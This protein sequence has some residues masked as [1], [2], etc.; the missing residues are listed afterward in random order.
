MSSRRGAG[1]GGR[2]LIAGTQDT[3]MSRLEELAY[4]FI[5]VEVF[6]ERYRALLQMRVVPKLA[7]RL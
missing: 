4:A 6:G 1:E 7:E 5:T 2:T 3:D